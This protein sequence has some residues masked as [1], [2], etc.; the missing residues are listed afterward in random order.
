[1]YVII[2]SVIASILYTIVI[3]VGVRGAAKESKKSIDHMLEV[4]EILEEIRDVLKLKEENG[5]KNDMYKTEE[6]NQ[7]TLTDLLVTEPTEEDYDEIIDMLVELAQHTFTDYKFLIAK[8]SDETK[9]ANFL[10]IVSNWAENPR[11][12]RRIFQKSIEANID[13]QVLTEK[14]AERVR[15]GKVVSLGDNAVVIVDDNTGNP[16]TGVSPINSGLEGGEI[17]FIISFV[18]KENFEDWTLNTF[19]E[20]E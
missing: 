3:W 17:A 15:Q 4:K 12:H 10:Q 1:M 7:L 5:M 13:R 8:S 18:K 14:F 11:L 16:P 9:D 20:E 2:Y 6:D 19:P